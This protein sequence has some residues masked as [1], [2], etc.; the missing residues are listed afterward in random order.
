LFVSLCTA[1]TY[2][3]ERSPTQFDMRS[4]SLYGAGALKRTSLWRQPFN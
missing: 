4:R 2:E 3:V 1:K